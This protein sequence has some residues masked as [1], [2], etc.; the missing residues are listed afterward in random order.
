MCQHGPAFAVVVVTKKWSGPRRDGA[1]V[2]HDAVLAQHQ[3]VARAADRQGGKGVGVD[4]IQEAGASRPCT[5]IL[6][7]VDTSQMPTAGAPRGP[8]AAPWPRR[9]LLRL[10]IQAGP[11]PVAGIDELGAVPDVPVVQRGRRTGACFRPTRAPAMAPQATGRRM[12]GTSADRR[13]RTSRRAPPPAPPRRQARR[14]CPARCPSCGW[15]SV[16]RARYG[17]SLRGAR[18]MSSAV[19]SSWISTNALPRRL[20]LP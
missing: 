8:R 6:P 4:A 13:L 10:R 3:P 2:E 9:R 18:R 11:Q 1:V 15:C 19:T 17:G 16:W 20:H 14:S 7:S 5:S 12:G